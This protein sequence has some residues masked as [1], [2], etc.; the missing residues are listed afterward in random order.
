MEKELGQTCT[1]SSSYKRF[2][3]FETLHALPPDFTHDNLGVYPPGLITECRPIR[4]PFCWTD[5]VNAVLDPLLSG[6]GIR[7]NEH[8]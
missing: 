7:S 5:F 6:A 2:I 1:H 3:D 8:T 4:D